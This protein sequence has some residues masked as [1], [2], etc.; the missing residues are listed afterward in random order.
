MDIK[1]MKSMRRLEGMEK[2]NQIPFLLSSFSI[3]EEA[4]RSVR[5]KGK[6]EFNEIDMDMR[7]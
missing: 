5:D 1:K 6:A 4:R 3:M 7:L 2:F